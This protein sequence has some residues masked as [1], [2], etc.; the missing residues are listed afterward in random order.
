MSLVSVL[1]ALNA[2]AG[3]AQS[4][5]AAPPGPLGKLVDVGGYRVHLYC[6]GSGSPS[7]VIAGAGYSFDWGL[8]QPEVAKFTR[9]CAYDHSGIAWSE[10]GPPD[11]CELR[12]SEIHAALAAAEIGAPF[13]LV[14]HSLG[15]LVARLYAA[16]H[17][18][19]V[20]GMVIVDHAMTLPSGM[21]P[22][23]AALPDRNRGFEKL[24]ERDYELHKWA[25]ALPGAE[26]AMRRNLEIA[27]ACDADVK[28][29]TAAQAH[30]LGGKPLIDV[31]ASR[32][33][34]LDLT[35]LSSNSK[36]VIVAGSG[37]FVMI[38]RPELVIAAILE[39]VQAARG[40]GKVAN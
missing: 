4:A 16:R 17:G 27:G 9:V 25:N 29:A 10:A 39:V 26:D 14:G 15:A 37:H 24:P 20:A 5:P 22:R 13:V 11:T 35:S 6:L 34:P 30:P 21:A 12:V 2:L 8:V 32:P 31:A 38:D 23:A 36:Q 7:V 18:G 28:T 19:D 3:W 33:G 40:G 1:F